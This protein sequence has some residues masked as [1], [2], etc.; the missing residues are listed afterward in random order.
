MSKKGNPNNIVN[1]GKIVF[2]INLALKIA[3]CEGIGMAVEK[4]GTSIY[5]EK[6]VL[7]WIDEQRGLVNRSVFVNDFLRKSIM[8]QDPKAFK[9]AQ[10]AK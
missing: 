1:N 9:Q 7:N 4:E 3:D 10:K 5:W 6:P 2:Y 8:Q